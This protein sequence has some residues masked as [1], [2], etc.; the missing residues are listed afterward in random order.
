MLDRETGLRHYR[1][2]VK[3]GHFVLT[4]GEAA[5]KLVIPVGDE[6]LAPGDEGPT[7]ET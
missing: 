7:P 4:G 2:P 1:M 5:L 3:T 6:P